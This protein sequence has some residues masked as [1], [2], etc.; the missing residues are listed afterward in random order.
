[1]FVQT[2]PRPRVNWLHPHVLCTKLFL[3]HR[4]PNHNAAKHKDIIQ[5]FAYKV[6]L[7]AFVGTDATIPDKYKAKFDVSSVGKLVAKIHLPMYER[8]KNINLVPTIFYSPPLFRSWLL[9]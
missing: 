4:D 6:A 8:K 3:F 1:M 2:N 7:R 5:I 9:K